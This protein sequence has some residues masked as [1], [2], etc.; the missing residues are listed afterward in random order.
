MTARFAFPKRYD[1]SFLKI[2]LS[3][4]VNLLKSC[5]HE[6]EMILKMAKQQWFRT[7]KNECFKKVWEA[8][9]KY[10]NNDVFVWLFSVKFISWSWVSFEF[11]TQHKLVLLFNCFL[12][13]VKI[14][15]T[16]VKTS[17]H[18]L[19]QCIIIFMFIL[20]MFFLM[21]FAF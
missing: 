7:Y 6:F 13:S 19:T 8:T 20:F 15:Y 16:L 2:A 4:N 9:A 5:G 10:N 14:C 17:H 11:I 21:F 12:G 18:L 1:S 3:I